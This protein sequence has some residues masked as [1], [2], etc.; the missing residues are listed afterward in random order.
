MRRIAFVFAFA[1]LAA[2][3]DVPA[4]AALPTEDFWKQPTFAR[5]APWAAGASSDYLF[6]S[7]CADAYVNPYS[8][9]ENVNLIH[10]DGIIE[11]S[12]LGQEGCFTPQ[13]EPALAVNP[14]NSKHLV[15][16]A[17]EYRDEV[18]VYVSLD[19]GESWRNVIVPTESPDEPFF[20][21]TDEIGGDPV[22][23]FGPDGTLYYSFIAFSRDYPVSG[24]GVSA[25]HDGGITWEPPVLVR[26]DVDP[27]I[28]HDKEWIAVDPNTGEVYVT[29]TR[30]EFSEYGEYERSPIV[31]SVSRDKGQTWTEPIEISDDQHPYN[32]GSIPQVAAD[33]TLW[34][35]F[36]SASPAQG[37]AHNVVALA[38]IRTPHVPKPILR[39]VARVWDDWNCYP[40]NEDWRHTLTGM[41]FRVSNLP[42]FAL[43]PTTGEMVIAWADNQGQA[44]CGDMILTLMD[45]FF[46]GES[47]SQVK[48]IT[49]ANGKEWTSPKTITSDESDKV[50]PAVDAYA[51]DI[52][53][54]YYT[55]AYAPESQLCS[56]DGQSPG[57]STCLD[58]AAKSSA[59]GFRD[60]QRVSDQSSNTYAQFGGRFIGDYNTV[61]ILPSGE[62]FAVWADS[63]GDPTR[64]TPNQDIYGARLTLSS[65]SHSNERWALLGALALLG[66]LIGVR[67]RAFE[68]EP[69]PEE[70]QP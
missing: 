17:N 20:T 65:S 19:G 55:R 49:S 6:R 61:V 13:N 62:A 31:L 22:L 11:V 27:T 37:Y 16:A 58:L 36:E 64:T 69:L 30:F 60:E 12:E 42:A 18:F 57:Q 8:S 47:S 70:P 46:L 23:A 33:G 4:G 59:D 7:L 51:G 24:I 15:A 39:E 43:D 1:L 40:F 21:V 25:S 66:I 29:W 5:L 35:A 53:I 38:E 32:Q 2:G 45:A 52:V 28:F 26:G 63:R 50:Y 44:N 10:E 41:N 48:I 68:E 9:S 54:T 34:V 14:Q 3:V 56:F 67:M